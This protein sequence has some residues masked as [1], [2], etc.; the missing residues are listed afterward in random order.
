MQP[1]M[2]AHILLL[3]MTCNL[4]KPI[5]VFCLK[6]IIQPQLGRHE[7]MNSG[8][9]NISMRCNI[10]YRP[11]HSREFLNLIHHIH[12][13]ALWFLQ[14][15]KHIVLTFTYSTDCARETS[16]LSTS[17]KTASTKYNISSDDAFTI[18]FLN[19]HADYSYT[20]NDSSPNRRSTSHT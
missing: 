16:M 18:D 9:V 20:G 11:L 12:M 13:V 10:A 1:L 7:C 3:I 6:R 17:T 15:S 19:P 14:V 5:Y 2:Q 4:R 8:N